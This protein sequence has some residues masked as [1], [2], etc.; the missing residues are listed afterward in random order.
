MALQEDRLVQIRTFIQEQQLDALVLRKVSSFAWATAG[1]R[2]Y[3]NTASSDGIGTLVVT[4]DEQFVVTNS[5]EAPRLDQEEGLGAAGWKLRVSPW[6]KADSTLAKLVEGKRTGA[7]FALPGAI[8]VSSA[9]AWQRSLLLP[10]EGDRFRALGKLCAAAMNEAIRSL[11]PGMTEYE[12]AAR[13]AVETERR[14]AQAIVN[15]IATDERIFQFRHPIPTGH[16][17]DR[18]AMLVLCG[19]QDGLVCS[20]TRLIRFGKLT[21]EL[22]RKEQAVA[23]IDGTF[24]LG[25]QPG[26]TLGDIFADAQAA[27]AAGGFP[28]QWQYHHQGGP[29]AY[30]PREVIATPG[31]AQVVAA[32]QVYA[33]NPSITGTK[34]EDTV[35]VGAD[36]NEV[37]TVIDGWPT[38]DVTVNGQTIARPAILEV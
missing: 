4:A 20:I 2:S 3:V 37:L 35:L 15:L 36:G 22:R 13:L 8:D 26:R 32:G 1:H 21:D 31:M 29:A 6:Y 24:I 25:T 11:T 23:Q 33:W 16:K 34:S 38:I 27:Y 30:E 12:I 17:L 7:D 5:I 14:G 10:E 9:L 18:Y 19:R 28:D